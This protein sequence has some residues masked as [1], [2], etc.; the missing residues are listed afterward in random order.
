MEMTIEDMKE[1]MA[2]QKA[3]ML[4]FE[5]YWNKHFYPALGFGLN[6]PAPNTKMGHLAHHIWKLYRVAIT[7]EGTIE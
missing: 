4:N 6:E 2:R 3:R 5:A 1:V 7:H